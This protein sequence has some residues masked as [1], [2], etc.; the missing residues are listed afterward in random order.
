MVTKG[1]ILRQEKKK[2]QKKNPGRTAS[3]H[4]RRRDEDLC[5]VREVEVQ[6]DSNN[7]QV[8]QGMVQENEKTEGPVSIQA[9]DTSKKK[10]GKGVQPNVQG[11]SGN[12]KQK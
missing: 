7:S 8:N 12:N 1:V 9:Q 4:E 3:G 2:Q 10:R 5:D 11:G 6:G